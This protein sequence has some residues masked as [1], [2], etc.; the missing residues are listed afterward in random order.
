LNGQ[1][2]LADT[3]SMSLTGSRFSSDSAH[4]GPSSGRQIFPELYKLVYPTRGR[5]TAE[6]LPSPGESFQWVTAQMW[7]YPRI[8][9][10]VGSLDLS[11][12]KNDRE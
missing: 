1:A 8:G 3:G 12:E 4:Q 5:A 7:L 11:V 9:P 6:M 10:T 2:A